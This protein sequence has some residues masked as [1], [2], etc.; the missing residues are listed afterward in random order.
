MESFALKYKT[1]LN[2][3]SVAVFFIIYAVCGV[4]GW[5]DVIIGA[6]ATVGA[7]VKM[8]LTYAISSFVFLAV[9]IALAVLG[10]LLKNKVM[11]LLPFC[12][13]ALLIVSFFLLGV[14]ATSNVTNLT[15][16]KL[17]IYALSA[18]L[19]PVY[20]AAWLL[21]FVIFIILIPLFIF[22]IVSIVAVFKKPK[23]SVKKK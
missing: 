20:G 18:I 16:Y 17:L 21:R 4:F 14:F 22:G 6:F 2:V 12:Y 8:P 7:T 15:V 1:R 9:M 11:V 19:V 5:F 23:I 13:Q 10:L 3:I